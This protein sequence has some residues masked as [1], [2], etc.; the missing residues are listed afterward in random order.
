MGTRLMPAHLLDM[1][2]ASTVSLGS[3]T[4]DKTA[5]I[6]HHDIDPLTK[7]TSNTTNGST[8]L[9][10]VQ[11]DNDSDFDDERD[12]FKRGNSNSNSSDLADLHTV[13]R[14]SSA[15]S[16]GLVKGVNGSSYTKKGKK[17]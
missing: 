7:Q 2:F 8:I 14:K 11:E 4:T 15:M 10:A 6:D 12:D 17:K 3:D 1:S 5:D 13:H 9:V 16:F